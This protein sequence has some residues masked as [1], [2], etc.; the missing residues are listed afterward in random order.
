MK[1]LPRES[2]FKL[3]VACDFC[4]RKPSVIIDAPTRRGP[5][6]HMCKMCYQLHA[7]SGA[8]SLGTTHQNEVA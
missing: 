4:R 5:W 1:K 2:R 7:S 6:A 3:S 8:A